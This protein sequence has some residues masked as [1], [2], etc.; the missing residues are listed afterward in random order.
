MVKN[1]PKDAFTDWTFGFG[2]LQRVVD[3]V[4]KAVERN[5]AETAE[6]GRAAAIKA[7]AD[8]S[9]SFVKR[10]VFA[11]M[12]AELWK[13]ETTFPRVLRNALL[14]AIYSHIEY[15]LL[16]WCESISP[17]PTVSEQ[18]KKRKNDE[19]YPGRYLRYLRD[20]AGIDLGDFTKW[21]EWELIDGYRRARNCLAHRG[22]I[23]DGEEDRQKIAT[24]PHIEIDDS[25]LQLIEPIVHLRPG[26]C[27]AASETAKAFVERAV[28]TA[29]RDA[30]WDGS[31]RE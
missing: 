22:G 12:A 20:D 24:L 16:S 2:D 17:D 3:L 13:S 31:K 29:Q 9:H 21:P 27:Q 5:A 19:S 25:G 7:A 28:T 18:L 23:V 6:A 15:L 11:P 10:P 14:V 1:L 4:E 30:R 26:A 8:P